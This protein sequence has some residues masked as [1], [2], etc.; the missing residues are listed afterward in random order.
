MNVKAHLVPMEHRVLMRSMVIIAF[1]HLYTTTHTAKMVKIWCGMAHREKSYCPSI[2]DKSR[3]WCTPPCAFE[4]VHISVFTFL[5]CCVQHGILGSWRMMNNFR[6]ILLL[7]HEL[8]KLWT[9]WMRIFCVPV[10]I[11]EIALKQIVSGPEIDKKIAS[12]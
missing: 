11:I 10:K 9:L 4:Y 12:E 7:R 3:S 1:V 8:C 5:P 2:E 6:R